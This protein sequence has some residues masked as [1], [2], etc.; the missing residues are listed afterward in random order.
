MIRTLKT[1]LRGSL[2][3]RAFRNDARMSN[4]FNY[5]NSQ[6]SNVNADENMMSM[7]NDGPLENEKFFSV[8]DPE[9]LRISM[10]RQKTQPRKKLAVKRALPAQDKY[11]L[12]HTGQQVASA[13]QS[14]G[15]F[16]L[17]NL[18]QFGTSRDWQ[19]T[20]FGPGPD[21][22]PADLETISSSNCWVLHFKVPENSLDDFHNTGHIFCFASGSV[23]TWNFK[24][25]HRRIID[26][27]LVPYHTPEGFPGTRQTPLTWKERV[28]GGFDRESINM[29]LSHT[30]KFKQIAID[31]FDLDWEFILNPDQPGWNSSFQDIINWNEEQVCQ[32]LVRVKLESLTNSFYRHKIT[33]KHLLMLTN[34][35][36]SE[37]CGP[38]GTRKWLIKELQILNTNVV[39]SEDTAQ[40]RIM[41]FDDVEK[42]LAIS[43]AMAQAA[44]LEVINHAIEWVAAA[45]KQ[46]TIEQSKLGRT[47]GSHRKISQLFGQHQLL[48]LILED[49]SVQP[50]ICSEP[51]F[52]WERS[53]L[54]HL[55]DYT[56]EHLN[57]HKK[58]QQTNEKWGFIKEAIVEERDY[59]T[60]KTGLR[61]ECYI[62]IILLWEI[63]K[64]MT[65][66]SSERAEEIGTVESVK[67]ED[68]NADAK[69]IIVIHENVVLDKP[70]V[71]T[72]CAVSKKEMKVSVDKDKIIINPETD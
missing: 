4:A 51:D 49:E 66:E 26:E 13:W 68:M 70:P 46:M 5:G 47:I 62:I 54:E 52:F 33:G 63:V 44:Q 28:L 34:K 18:Y 14:G 55:Y 6:T 31:D 23:V 37:L 7:E 67:A 42:L 30:R 17:P 56:I 57:H 25:R 69:K 53:Q 72:S 60:E 45:V 29:D 15:H 19:V 41:D 24:G 3:Q 65:D 71:A 2:L 61:L 21:G 9:W 8:L 38:I 58:A 36:I 27:L 1:R 22:L 16:D 40:I 50:P 64:S 48:K 20:S 43:F 35:E 11:Y 39:F 32:W 12:K 59:R 10:K